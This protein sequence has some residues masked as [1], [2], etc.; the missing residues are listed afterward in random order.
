MASSNKEF[1]DRYDASGKER[2]VPTITLNDLLVRTGVPA[3][4]FMTMDI[5]L[6]EPKALAGFDLAKLSAP[7]GVRR[8]ASGHSP[9][10]NQPLRRS[11]VSCGGPVLESQSLQPLVRAR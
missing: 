4:D 7:S 6:A 5:E 11:A 8:G 9:T 10:V 2:K 3:I 1:S